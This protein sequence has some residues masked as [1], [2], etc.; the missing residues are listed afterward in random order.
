MWRDLVTFGR[1]RLVGPTFAGRLAVVCRQTGW[2]PVL[3]SARA[4]TFRF[5]PD[6]RTVTAVAT[7][8]TAVVRLWATGRT[9]FPAKRFPPVLWTVLQMRNRQ[10]AEDQW[11]MYETASSCW[12]LLETVVPLDAWDGPV[13]RATVAR[14]YRELDT[15]DDGW[16]RFGRAGCGDGR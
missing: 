12:P 11:Q 13:M 10:L 2:T 7:P 1:E 5:G 14:L 15:L 4:A 6:P 16:D 8:G 3:R 9:D